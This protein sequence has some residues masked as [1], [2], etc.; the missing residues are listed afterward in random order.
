MGGVVGRK[1]KPLE[2]RRNFK[3]VQRQL[4]YSL[5]RSLSSSAASLYRSIRR[6]SSSLSSSIRRRSS[7]LSKE[8]SNEKMF[9]DYE[10]QLIRRSWKQV[11]IDKEKFSMNV[12]LRIFECEPE[13]KL[14]FSWH[15]IETDKL[16]YQPTFK[17]QAL[18]ILNVIDKSVQ[19]LEN[20][21]VIA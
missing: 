2:K 18:A 10:V 13:L 4:N 11:F 9:S 12:Y 6:F 19:C 5:S 16:I 8:K 21:L 17:R 14:F 1:T 7:E 15:D 20:I 3:H